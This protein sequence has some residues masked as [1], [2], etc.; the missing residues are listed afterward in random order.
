M[1]SQ[2]PLDQ[3][4]FK[5]RVLLNKTVEFSLTCLSCSPI[6]A[7]SSGSRHYSWKSQFF[8]KWQKKKLR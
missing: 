6:D 3:F 5:I 8:H 4:I 7:L 2:R 1:L